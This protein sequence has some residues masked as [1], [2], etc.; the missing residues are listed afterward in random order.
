[1]V[2]LSEMKEWL[3]IYEDDE[4]LLINSLI[5]SSASIIQSA[6]GISKEYIIECKN[7]R[8]KDLYNMV[9]R[10]LIADLYNE[11]DVE[12]RA[13]TALYIQLETAYIGE[14]NNEIR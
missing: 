8:I 14:K 10:I 3:R 2:E 4:D 9:Q 6:T 1:M 7:Y 11:R 12:N 5:Q 13:L